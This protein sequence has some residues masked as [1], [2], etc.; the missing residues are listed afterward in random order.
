MHTFTLLLGCHKEL[1]EPLQLQVLTALAQQQQLPADQASEKVRMVLHMVA[2]Q[3]ATHWQ[4]CVMCQPCWCMS[5]SAQ[6]SPM[7]HPTYL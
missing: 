1:P 6:R 5:V 7:L 2:A 4:A 3:P